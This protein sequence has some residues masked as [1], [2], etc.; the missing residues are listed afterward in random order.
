M[1]AWQPGRVAA[2]HPPLAAG[3]LPW[4]QLTSLHF[5]I[6]SDGGDPQLITNF[7]AAVPASY[8]A[9]LYAR[10][11]LHGGHVIMLGPDPESR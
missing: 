1:V 10:D 5:A 2:Q 9:E 4:W 6:R 3:G 7:E 11:G 8:F